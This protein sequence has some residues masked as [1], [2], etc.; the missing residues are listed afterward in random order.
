MFPLGP[1]KPMFP[2]WPLGPVGPGGPVRPSC[3]AGPWTSERGRE[4]HVIK[5]SHPKS[6]GL[7]EPKFKRNLQQVPPFLVVQCF[8]GFLG[9]P[10]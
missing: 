4:M 5:E 1:G 7:S 8:Q 6:S 3:P 10:V 2:G 9:I